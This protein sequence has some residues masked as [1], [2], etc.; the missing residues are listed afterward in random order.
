M[1]DTQTQEFTPITSQKELDRVLGG[2][3]KDL[4]EAREALAQENEKLQEALAAKEEEISG[5]KEEKESEISRLRDEHY[6]A[7]LR[8]TLLEELA[9][10]GVEGDRAERVLRHVDVEKV[11]RGADGTPNMH[12]LRS[13]LQA[14]SHDL[15]E[16]LQYRMGAGSRGSQQAVIRDE[17]PLTREQVESMSPEEINAPGTWERVQRFL[18]GDRG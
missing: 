15:P 5:L 13:Q 2:R 1:T 12:S 16:L 18:A 4:R 6:Q 14:V 11:D 8:R 17:E 7:D 9:S 10:A 3:L